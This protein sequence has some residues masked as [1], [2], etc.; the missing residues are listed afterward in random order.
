MKKVMLEMS[1]R[2]MERIKIVGL[3]MA[4]GLTQVEASEQMGVGYRQVKRIVRRIKEEGDIGV[5]HRLRGRVSGRQI[6]GEKKS[7][8][9]ELYRTK[10]PDFGTTFFN[11]KLAEMHGIKISTESVRQ[12]LISE[13]LHKAKKQ[14]DKGVHVWRERKHH[15]GEMVQID[16]SHHRWL[17]GRLDQEFCLMGYID[18]ATSK[19]YARFYEYEGILP[20]LDSF[21]G[22]VRENGIPVSVYLDRHSTYKVNRKTTVE[23]DLEGDGAQTQFQRVMKQMGVKII[24]ARSPQAKG[25]VERL[26][27]TLQDRLVKELRLAGVTTIEGANEFLIP[28]LENHNNRFQFTPKQPVSLFKK[29]PEQ[30]DYHWTFSIR[31]VRTIG[32]DYTIRFCT[33]VFLIVAPARTLCKQR[34]VIRQAINGE[35][36]FETKHR[37]LTV[38]EVTEKAIDRVKQAQKELKKQLRKP[39]SKSQPA[40][41]STDPPKSKKSWMD[42]MHFGRNSFKSSQPQ[43]KEKMPVAC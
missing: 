43:Q 11:E 3:V 4:K 37:I 16:G 14:K 38:K 20:V 19:V 7:K 28:Y 32:K 23:E 39:Q 22:F 8:I 10:Y 42:N 21:G 17:E 2:E 35:L 18:D 13:G 27:E 40:V 12:I 25:R 24:H 34:V 5:I 36:R 30:F 6:S 31:S 29:V 1:V 33:R 15:E 9:A 41:S 26:F